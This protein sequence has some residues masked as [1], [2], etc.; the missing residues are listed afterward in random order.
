MSNTNIKS[1]NK[2]VNKRSFYKN[3]RIF[4][5]DEIDTK[6]ILVSKKGIIC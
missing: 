3:K 1:E 4:N 5:I 2:K 6:K